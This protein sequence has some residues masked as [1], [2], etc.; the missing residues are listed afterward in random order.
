MCILLNIF[1]ATE[2]VKAMKQFFKTFIIM[3]YGY[4]SYVVFPR[5]G[6]VYKFRKVEK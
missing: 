2:E 5:E 1:S 6:T 4:K 3:Q